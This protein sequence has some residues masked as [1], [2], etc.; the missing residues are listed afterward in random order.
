MSK[1]IPKMFSTLENRT[2]QHLIRHY[3]IPV[4]TYAQHNVTWK[5]K[6]TSQ[7]LDY[8]LLRNFLNL[9]KFLEQFLEM[10][11]EKIMEIVQSTLK[12][13]KWILIS[14]T[15]SLNVFLLKGNDKQS[16][17]VIDFSTKLNCEK[18]KNLRKSWNLRRPKT[19]LKICVELTI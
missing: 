10:K 2:E 14:D 7:P 1:V 8:D 11:S 9:T 16:E 6:Q 12:E 17:W 18:I 5:W 13:S 4:S 19:T 3:W 15:F